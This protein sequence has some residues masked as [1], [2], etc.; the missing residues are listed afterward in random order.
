MILLEI[1]KKFRDHERLLGEHRWSEMLTEPDN[2][3]ENRVSQIFHSF[4]A[5][6]RD[7]QKDGSSKFQFQ[8][9]CLCNYFFKLKRME[10]SCYQVNLVQKLVSRKRVSNGGFFFFKKKKNSQE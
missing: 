8:H 2:E 3:Q 4:Y 7:A 10:K 9:F 5:K 1:S 6:G